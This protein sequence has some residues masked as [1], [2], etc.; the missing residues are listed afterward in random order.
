MTAMSRFKIAVASVSFVSSFILRPRFLF[1]PNPFTS[2][3]TISISYFYKYAKCFFLD[4]SKK[5]CDNFSEVRK[6]AKKDHS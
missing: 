1:P 3:L 6:N 4:L 5:L 2:F